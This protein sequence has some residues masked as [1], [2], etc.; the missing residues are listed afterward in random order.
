M[1][2]LPSCSPDYNPIEHLWKKIKTKATHNHY[3]AEFAKLIRS[4]E[5]A[6]TILATQA[7]EI[8]RLMGV[9]TKQMDQPLI[10]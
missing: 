7:D 10:A 4:V 1:H 8:K 9:Y 6:L 3:F 2:Q 5:E